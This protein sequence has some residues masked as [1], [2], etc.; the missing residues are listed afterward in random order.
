MADIA[1]GF[2]LYLAVVIEK[3]RKRSELR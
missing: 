2:G 1:S 3:N